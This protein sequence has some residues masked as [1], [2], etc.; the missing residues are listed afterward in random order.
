MSTTKRPKAKP[1]APDPTTDKYR[2]SAVN[3][4]AG[5][6]DLLQ[7]VAKARA[8]QRGGRPSVS[9]VLTTLIDASRKALQAEAATVVNPYD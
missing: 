9:A 4:R 1:S 3:L 2:A 7:W 8:K 5:D 6:W